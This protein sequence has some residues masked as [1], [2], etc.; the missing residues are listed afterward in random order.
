MSCRRCGG[1]L[2]HTCGP[3]ALKLLCI[4]GTKHVLNV[5]VFLCGLLWCLVVPAVCCI[6]RFVRVVGTHNTVNRVFHLVSFECFYSSQSCT[7]D[8]GIIGLHLFVSVT[9]VA[10]YF[11]SNIFAV[12]LLSPPGCGKSWRVTELKI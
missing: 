4:R 12:K 7:L 9:D 11:L 3:P 2:F 5:V 1:K 8:G 6:C 10:L